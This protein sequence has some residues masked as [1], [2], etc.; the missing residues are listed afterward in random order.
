MAKKSKMTKEEYKIIE[1]LRIQGLSVGEIASAL[2]RPVEVV[3]NYLDKHP[4]EEEPKVAKE[5]TM[6]QKMMNP[7]HVHPQSPKGVTIMSQAVGERLDDSRQSRINRDGSRYS[8]TNIHKIDGG[9]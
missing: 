6:V 5:P 1:N 2:E 4:E 3:Q 8:K 9:E 7:H